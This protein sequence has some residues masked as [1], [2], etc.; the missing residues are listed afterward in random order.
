MSELLHN[1]SAPPRSKVVVSQ[2]Q[3]KKYLS[4]NPIKLSKLL[5]KPHTTFEELKLLTETYVNKHPEIVNSIEKPTGYM[6]GEVV[7]LNNLKAQPKKI[8]EKLFKYS[9]EEC[10]NLNLLIIVFCCTVG[11]LYIPNR[12]LSFELSKFDKILLFPKEEVNS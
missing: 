3:L 2:S 10:D 7:E 5:G 8:K 4:F 12:G 9:Y 6:I 1:M 11:D